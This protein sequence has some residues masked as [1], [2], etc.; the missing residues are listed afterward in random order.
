MIVINYMYLI[1][2]FLFQPFLGPSQFHWLSDYVGQQE[3]QSLHFLCQDGCKDPFRTLPSLL[4]TKIIQYLDPMTLNRCRQVCQ[5][6]KHLFESEWIWHRMCY[7]PKWKLSSVE[8]HVQLE[9][10][11]QLGLSWRKVFK[12]R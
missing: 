6:W 12:E 7:L 2:S 3:D 1:M 9:R 8:D 11:H 5:F 4:N 10:H